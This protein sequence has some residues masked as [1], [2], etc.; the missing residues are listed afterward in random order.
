MPSANPS[1]PC[2]RLPEWLRIK[3]PRDPSFARTRD[4]VA[5]LGLNTVCQGARCPNICECFARSTATFLILGRSCTRACAFCNIGPG[6]VEPVDPGE[7]ARVAEAAKRLGLTHAVVTSVTRDDLPDG[8]AAHFAATIRA[9]RQARPQATVEVLIPDFRGSEAALRLVLDAR[10]DVLNHNVETV[11]GL[12]PRIRPQA[13]YAQSLTLLARAAAAGLPAKSGLMVGLGETVAEVHQVIRDLHAQG[14][15]IVTIGQYLR[16]SKAH[17]EPA[18][19]V[20]P[21]EFAA[22]AEF[23]RS[24]GVPHMFCAPLVRSSYHA[25]EFVGR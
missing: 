25:G 20:H 7:P 12:Y 1:K 10:P 24:L 4:L 19:Y 16:P 6:R 18:R 14:V 5:D 21:D 9:L 2:S 8:G 15:T 11:P 17:P 13:D 23:G 3:L 22:L